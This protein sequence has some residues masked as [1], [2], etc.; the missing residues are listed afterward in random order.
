MRKQLI[1]ILASCMLL[2]STACNNQDPTTKKDD[3]VFRVASW[4]E[5]ID[6]GGSI[7]EEDDPDLL[8]FKNWFQ[9][10]TGIDLNN[11]RPI[12][13]EF[14]DWYNAQNPDHPIVVEYVALQDN[15]TMYNK[16]K[17]NDEYDLLC[18]SEYMAMKLKA[19][20]LL[21]A[22]DAS[23]FDPSLEENFY[24]QNVSAYT[25]EIFTKTGLSEYIAG[26]MWGT[27]GFVYNPEPGKIGRTAQETRDIMSRW[28]CLTSD[29]CSRKITAKDN[30]RD[31]YFMGLGMYYEKEL[32]ALDPTAKDYADTLSKKMNDVSQ[33]TM[34]NVKVLLENARKNLYGLETDEG[35]MDVAMGRLDAS[36]QWSGDAVY[37]LDM[38]EEND[39]PLFLE[40]SI[41]KS[42]SNLWF[43]GWVM[44]NGANKKIAQA[45]VNYISRP[46]NVI[47]NMYYIGYTSC[48][49]GEKVY[50]YVDYTYSDEEGTAS[51]DL[52]YFFGDTFAP[53]TVD[54]TQTRRQ[55][56]AQYPDAVTKNR[57]VVMNYFKPDENERANRMWNNIK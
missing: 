14:Q 52:S 51:Y 32:L 38:A 53:L 13:E 25:K 23:F 19:E 24:A 37:I 3:N 5:Y 9:E 4:D 31:S 35:K 55:L 12:Y 47:R 16:I 36:Y 22:Y 11:T 40:Y 56:F 48:I 15:E 44:M 6:M 21:Q 34:A 8:D 54:E 50:D 1:F 17:M 26:Y 42:A 28:D 30:V 2:C 27:T 41:P 7:Y 10:L 45:F 57:L 43:D 29:A 20:G 46:E 33:E 39:E 49:A 18:P